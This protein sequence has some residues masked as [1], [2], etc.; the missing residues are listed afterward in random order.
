MYTEMPNHYSWN[1]STTSWTRRR[2]LTGQTVIGRMYSVSPLD[3]NR[4]HLRLL[5]LF[6][7]GSISFADLRTVNGVVHPTY[8]AAAIALG[9]LEND[10]AW[11]DCVAEAAI[12]DSPRQLR[13]QFVTLCLYCS[14][15]SPLELYTANEERMMEDFARNHTP[16]EARSA[17]LNAIHHLLHFNGKSLEDYGLLI[18]VVLN[19]PRDIEYNATTEGFFFKP[20]CE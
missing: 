5:L 1:K 16:H 10:S 11:R 18:P 6:R 14:P 8:E 19:L 13:A 15:S 4:F 9:L 17:C 20:I 7:R 12:H 3:R 2:T